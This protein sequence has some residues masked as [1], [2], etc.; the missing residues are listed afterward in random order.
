[1]SFFKIDYRENGEIFHTIELM[2]GNDP[3]NIPGIEV[4]ELDWISCSM[5]DLATCSANYYIDDGLLT[6]RP[7]NNATIDKTTITADGTDEAIITGI[8]DQSTVSITSPDT[9]PLS[10]VC[11]DGQVEFSTETLGEYIIN[12]TP[13]FPEQTKTFT[14]IAV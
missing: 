9:D 7:T 11:I 13:P 3:L 4:S 5:D 8:T 2:P 10:E 14:V 6:P 1:M 12:I